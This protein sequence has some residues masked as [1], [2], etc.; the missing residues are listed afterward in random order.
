VYDLAFSPAGNLLATG[1]FD[2]T[3]IVWEME[4]GEPLHTFAGHTNDIYSIAFNPDGS[5]L[6]TGSSDKTIRLWSV[7]TG[8]QIISPLQG[9]RAAVEDI[10]FSLD[11]KTMLSYDRDALLMA[12]N[13]ST[14]TYVRDSVVTALGNSLSVAYSPDGLLLASGGNDEQVILIDTTSKQTLHTLTH[15]DNVNSV[16]FS[17]DSRWLATGSDDGTLILW[18]VETGEQ[19]DQLADA[20]Q[21]D[22]NSIAVSPDGKWLA[23]GDD[24]NAIILWDLQSRG[25]Y[26]HLDRPEDNLG[27]HGDVRSMVF[28]PDGQLLV[29]GSEDNTLIVWDVEQRSIIHTLRGHGGNVTS[30]AFSPDGTWLASGGSDDRV[31]LWDT[32]TFQQVGEPLIEHRRWISS[33]A[34]SPDSRLLATG[35]GDEHIILWDLRIRHAIGSPIEVGDQVNSITFS[36]DPDNTLLAVGANSTPVMVWDLSVDVWMQKACALVGRNLTWEEWQLHRPGQQYRPTCPE[37]PLYFGELV[38]QANSYAQAGQMHRAREMYTDAVEQ[39]D[40]NRSVIIS[41]HLCWQGS[42][43]GLAATVLPVCEQAVS[44]T[45]NSEAFADYHAQF[46]DSRGLALALNGMYDRAIADFTFFVEWTRSSEASYERYGRKREQWIHALQ[47]GRDPFD[48]ITLELLRN[49]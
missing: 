36:P 28:S 40:K 43:N 30:V 1:S 45:A 15:E 24:N 27:H 44:L 34:F 22:V 48:P 9:H 16:V 3:I 21:N 26:I 47:E 33:I 25:T 37:I 2:N 17:P 49:E 14:G 7:K 5:L 12:W 19:V 11:G 42:L 8:Q 35:S 10:Y 32:T 13:V 38:R 23:S 6:A 31:I 29:S 20:H 41:N 46:R 4:N 18:D 39:A